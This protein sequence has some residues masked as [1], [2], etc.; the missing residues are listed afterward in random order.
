[1]K[2]LSISV[3]EYWYYYLYPRG[4]AS[5]EGFAEYLT[6]HYASF[7]P[8][9]K[10]NQ[11]GCVF[12]YFIQEE[13]EDVYVNVASI[14]EISEQNAEI[15]PRAEY[16]ERLKKAVRTKCVRCARYEREADPDGDD[17][18]GHREKISLDGQCYLFEE[19]KDAQ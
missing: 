11:N 2:I 12:P 19:R 7:I 17:L 15:L 8:L 18:S 6:A 1:M 3:G 10:L 16:D 9:T 13:R 4:I 5:L 14:I